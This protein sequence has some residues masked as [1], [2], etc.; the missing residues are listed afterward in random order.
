MGARTETAHLTIAVNISAASSASRTLSEQ[1]LATLDRTGADP[2]NLE[3]ELTES[4]LVDNIE[5]I[6]AKMT[7]LKLHGLGFSLDDFGTGYSSLSYLKR[8]PLDQMKIDRAFVHDIWWT[9]P[10][11]PLRKPSSPWAGPWVCRLLAEGVKDRGTTGLPHP[12]G[13]PCLPGIPVQ[14]PLPWKR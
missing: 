10:A 9:S 4:M 7:E 5:D 3:L 1:V 8:L 12:S 13:L 2:Q 11:A 14:P 6:I